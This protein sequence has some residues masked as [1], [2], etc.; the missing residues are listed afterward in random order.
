MEFE[1][2][3]PNFRAE[4]IS[5][6]Q[7][8]VGEFATSPVLQG[9]LGQ[10]KSTLDLR[11]A[12]DEGKVLVVNLAKG[13][14]GEDASALLGSLLVTQLGQAALS[15]AEIS[16]PERRDFFLYADEFPNFTTLAFANLLAEARKYRLN[17]ILAHQHL[18]QLDPLVRDAILGNVGTAICFR[19]GLADAL[20][21]E[22]E[23]YPDFRATDLINL[24][25][26]HIY[27]K[28]MINGVV[29][30]PFSAVTLPPST[31]VIT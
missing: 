10:K 25:K 28:L 22:K 12:M 2:Y 11:R 14:V 4:A 29:S 30:K 31:P 7:N 18:G 1:R 3:P 17:L 16:E 24:P 5:S 13:R 27:L 15:R 9:I 20:E 8:K 21:L 19:T 23:F 26:Y 6:I